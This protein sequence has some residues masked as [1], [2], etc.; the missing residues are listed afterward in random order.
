M[1]FDARHLTRTESHRTRANHLAFL[2][3]SEPEELEASVAAFHDWW[4]ETCGNKLVGDHRLRLRRRHRGSGRIAADGGGV[5]SW[6][7]LSFA[8]LRLAKLIALGLTNREVGAQMSLSRRA[9]SSRLRT[10]FGVLGI[11]SREELARLAFTFVPEDLRTFDPLPSPEPE[12]E[13]LAT[14]TLL[15]SSV[16]CTSAQRNNALTH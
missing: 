3:R 5:A 8:D 1:T 4:S 16:R 11:G 6:S 14:I 9:V 13:H 12:P 15:T 7:S 2:P 10:I